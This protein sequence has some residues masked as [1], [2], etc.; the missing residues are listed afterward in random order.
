MNEAWCGLCPK[1][2]LGADVC[3]FMSKSNL[4]RDSCILLSLPSV[5]LIEISPRAVGAAS[6]RGE[7]ADSE[8]DR[9][10]TWWPG[11]SCED[12]D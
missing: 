10:W 2:H 4:A 5:E 6:G 9:P 7:A 8:M 11:P 1:R 12:V 3:P